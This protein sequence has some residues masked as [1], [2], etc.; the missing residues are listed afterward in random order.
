MSEKAT[1]T[2]Q[3]WAAQILEAHPE[4]S[5][6][7]Q[8]ALLRIIADTIVSPDGAGWRYYG[9]SDLPYVRRMLHWY[10]TLGQHGESKPGQ[11]GPG[12]SPGCGDPLC[13]YPGHQVS[14][15][16]AERNTER[17]ARKR[18]AAL[19]DPCRADAVAW[20]E[21]LRGLTEEE[22]Q[23]FE[24]IISQVIVLTPGDPESVW[25]F[26][27]TMGEREEDKGQP[28]IRLQHRN[29]PARRYMYEVLKS[30]ETGERVEVSQTEYVSACSGNPRDV[31]PANFVL[32]QRRQE[33]ESP[34][35]FSDT[36]VFQ[37]RLARKRRE[38]A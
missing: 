32:K 18:Q 38:E 31:N 2:P 10:L 19:T 33:A 16:A 24:Q 36:L 34:L 21:T 25:K 23:N 20:L 15:T 8:Q 9:P 13:V 5:A 26:T 29:Q 28:T 37:K 14:K 22:R 4:L 3:A 6:R 1:I 27:C 30:I 12:V 17:W 7:K 11:G 35:L